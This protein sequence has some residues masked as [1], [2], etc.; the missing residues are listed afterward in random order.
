MI[1]WEKLYY[2]LLET[3]VATS[4]EKHHILPKHDGGAKDSTVVTMSRRDHIL[5]HYI[6]Y[7]WK[8]Q[9]GDKLAYKMMLGQL[10]NPMQMG[11]LKGYRIYFIEKENL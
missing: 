5:S 8:N 4:G 3:R 7:R 11:N 6:R 1:N 2:R 10:V 9:L